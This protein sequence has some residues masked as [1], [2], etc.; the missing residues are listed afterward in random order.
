MT[1]PLPAPY[2]NPPQNQTHLKGM[3]SPQ[4][5]RAYFRILTC[6]KKLFVV[7]RNDKAHSFM[8]HHPP[9]FLFLTVI[10][11]HAFIMFHLIYFFT[12]KFFIL[13]FL[14]LCH[15][16]KLFPGQHVM[17][18]LY[19]ASGSQKQRND[20]RYSMTIVDLQHSF[21]KNGKFAIFIVPQGEF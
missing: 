17:V 4:K 8:Y 6:T 2:I 11:L 15:S 13:F 19:L 10:Q 1:P 21:A 18:D 3:L 14:C 7:I 12:L 16:E 20:P 9:K 5:P